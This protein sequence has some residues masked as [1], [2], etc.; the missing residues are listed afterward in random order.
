M[1]LGSHVGLG[2]PFVDVHGAHLATSLS[3]SKYIDGLYSDFIT[4]HFMLHCQG[5]PGAVASGELLKRVRND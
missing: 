3:L 4:L 1:C 5:D 2:A